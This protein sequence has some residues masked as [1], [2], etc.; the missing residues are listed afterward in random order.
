MQ[1]TRDGAY[2]VRN[3]KTDLSIED[4]RAANKRPH[5]KFGYFISIF[6]QAVSPGNTKNSAV[7]IF[8]S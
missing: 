7:A 3:T 2:R 1:A 4:G 5:K 6:Q 8:E